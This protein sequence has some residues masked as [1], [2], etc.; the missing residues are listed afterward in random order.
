MLSRLP[1][2]MLHR[3]SNAQEKVNKK[4]GISPHRQVVGTVP[5]KERVPLQYRCGAGRANLPPRSRTGVV[6]NQGTS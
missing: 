1:H 2:Q 4:S 5:L 6:D 3:R